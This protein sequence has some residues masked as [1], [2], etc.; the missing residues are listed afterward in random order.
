MG[1]ANYI[2]SMQE[3]VNLF[4]ITDLKFPRLLDEEDR[5][6]VVDL[7]MDI[8]DSQTEEVGFR[9]QLLMGKHYTDFEC[10]FRITVHKEIEFNIYRINATTGKRRILFKRLFVIKPEAEVID[11]V[12]RTT[13]EIFVKGALSPSVYARLVDNYSALDASIR[14]KVI[15]WYYGNEYKNLTLVLPNNLYIIIPVKGVILIR[16]IIRQ[17]E[18]VEFKI[19]QKFL[20]TL[21]VILKGHI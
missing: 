6:T 17:P 9:K 15:K 10:A 14:D 21:H 18:Y 11:K 3:I 19:T 5:K 2:V 4:K 1:K 20:P 16:V 13:D 8:V 7:L 12:I